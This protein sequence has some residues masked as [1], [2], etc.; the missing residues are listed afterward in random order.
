MSV[1]GTFFKG[2]EKPRFLESF[3]DITKS[4]EMLLKVNLLI[5]ISNDHLLD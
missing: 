4:S 3:L 2:V 5:K 1:R